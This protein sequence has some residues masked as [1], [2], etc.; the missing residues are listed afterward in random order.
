[1]GDL[2]YF[3][4]GGFRSLKAVVTTGQL[5]E[6]DVGAPIQSLTRGINFTDLP[7]PASLWSA[8]RAQYLCAIGTTM[9]VFTYSPISGVSGW[10]TY[11]L[12]SA[13]DSMVELDGNL[14]IRFVGSNTI[15]V[16]D[17]AYENEAGF[18][19]EV[20]FAFYDG[21][22][23]TVPKNWRILDH[24]LVGRATIAYMVEPEDESFVVNAA[25]VD[26][27][28]RP[29]RVYPF[30]V[31]NHIAPKFTGTTPFRLDRFTFRYDMGNL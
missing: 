19:W 6:G 15:Y 22:D 4:L 7:K 8:A 9:Y 31:S 25:I 21:E 29:N 14:Y 27:I 5:N 12:P 1:M 23:H 30:V 20:R 24:A 10:T 28:D 3:S 17:P 2:F 16:F 11:T 18:T 26:S 13:V